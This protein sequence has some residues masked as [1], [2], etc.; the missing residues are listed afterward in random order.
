MSGRRLVV[1]LGVVALVVIGLVLARGEGDQAPVA[2][3]SQPAP[4]AVPAVSRS[5]SSSSQPTAPSGDATDEA[6]HTTAAELDENGDEHLDEAVPSPA[7]A[8]AVWDGQV[9]TAATEA[10]RGAL[11]A[12][13]RPA[14]SV[15]A[16][17]WW[18]AL[19]PTLSSAAVPV[20]SSV[21]PR[22]VPYTQVV[23]V[24]PAQ[25]AGSDL[26][27]SVTATT[28]A[29]AYDVLLSRANGASPWLVEQLRPKEET[30]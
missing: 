24:D 20:Y 8:P 4:R 18:A 5:A 14:A 11:K 7:P 28:D 29:G 12:F 6:S 3:T 17:A 25:Q 22:L 23:Q 2:S 10:A 26:L 27:A 1:V 9:A 19:Q 13:A 21:D 16:A 15:D 30:P